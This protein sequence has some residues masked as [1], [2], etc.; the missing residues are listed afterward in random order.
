MIPVVDDSIAEVQRRV[1]GAVRAM[2][3][4]RR[5]RHAALVE[6][7]AD[8][9][10][11]FGPDSA[12]W[13]VHR[14]AAMFV[15]GLR[16]LLLQTLHPLAMAG[17]ADH[18]DYR[19]DPWGRLHRTADFIGTTTY[20]TTDVAM[21]SIARVRTIHE[22]VR[23]TAPD[24]RPYS[25]TDPRLIAWVHVTEVD[26]FLRANQRYGADRLDRRDAD[27]Y[28]AEMSVVA[29]LLGSEPVPTT[30]A[31][32][33]QWL[34]DIRPELTAGRQA[35]DAVRFLLLPPVALVARGPY[36]L[37]AAASVGLLPGWARR[38]LWLPNPP[39]VDPILVQ[40][41]ARFLL[42]SLGWALRAD[43]RSA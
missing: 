36:S 38:H 37:I 9:P 23:G 35:R 11:L 18:S 30:V 42:A 26:S 40:P 14:D 32:L 3:V 17:V 28:V 15:G 2:V 22:R 24:G 13:R 7:G 5:R 8:D 25:A 20:G 43:D 6:A 29:D 10:G 21:R 16:A 34:D 39:L 31:E 19:T 41:S 4:G 12:A 33:R 1:A 27:R